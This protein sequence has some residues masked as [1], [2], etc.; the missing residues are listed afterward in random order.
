MVTDTHLSQIKV[1]VCVRARA[2]VSNAAITIFFIFAIIKNLPKIVLFP[3][4]K[5]ESTKLHQ[6]VMNTLNLFHNVV[7][8]YNINI[9]TMVRLYKRD[10]PSRPIKYIHFYISV[11]YYKNKNKT[12]KHSRVRLE[13]T[14]CNQA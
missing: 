10:A 9:K 3:S 11:I 4:S 1:G 14:H 8:Q 13:F 2:L 5:S 12:K 6:N 7:Q